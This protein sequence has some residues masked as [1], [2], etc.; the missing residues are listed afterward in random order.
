MR[1]WHVDPR[2][3]CRQHLLGEHVEHHMIAAT[4]LSGKSLGRH[5]ELGQI[6]TRTLKVRHDAIVKE[7]EARG[8]NH[9]SPFI[10]PVVSAPFGW[11]DAED[12]LRELLRRCPEC[13][14][15]K[16]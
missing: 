13:A 9:K 10:Q 1:Q 4:I 7:M 6:D 11:F 3:M 5:L 14:K 16:L 12:N 15:I 8:Y 2:R